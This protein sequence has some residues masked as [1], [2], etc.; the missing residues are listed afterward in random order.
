MY[1][2]LPYLLYFLNPDR[3]NGALDTFF[4]SIGALCQT[5]EAAWVMWSDD[6]GAAYYAALTAAAE[7]AVKSGDDWVAVVRG[8]EQRSSIFDEIREVLVA[9]GVLLA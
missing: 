1:S 5:N 6:V 3:E 2:E 7:F 8:Y 4:A 9:R